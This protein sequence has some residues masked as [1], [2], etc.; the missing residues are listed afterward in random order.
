MI[1][2]EEAYQILG[3]CFETYNNQGS[4]FLEAFYQ[5]C[6]EIELSK[7]NIPFQSQQP[8]QL[9]YKGIPLNQKYVP[10][11]ICFEKIILEIK[12]HKSIAQEHRAQIINYLKA[13]GIQLGLLVNFGHHTKLEYE[14]FPNIL[15]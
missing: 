15:S 12:A 13:T 5:E 9:Y 14:R 2:K 4:G 1:Y 7:R 6:L 11:F 10:D 3:A 8:I